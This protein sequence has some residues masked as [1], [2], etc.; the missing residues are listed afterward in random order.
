M[1]QLIKTALLPYG[2]IVEENGIRCLNGQ[3]I[4]TEVSD[5]SIQIVAAES[6]GWAIRQVVSILLNHP[7]F[8]VETSE[9][10]DYIIRVVDGF[11]KIRDS[12]NG[13]LRRSEK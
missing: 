9:E 11:S 10:G 6:S 7:G 13:L 12:V 4:V 8:L 2:Y 1:F 3:R 5:N